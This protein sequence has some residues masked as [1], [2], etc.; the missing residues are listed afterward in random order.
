M[1]NI[2][3]KKVLTNV[4]SFLLGKYSCEEINIILNELKQMIDFEESDY[5]DITTLGLSYED[6]QLLLSKINEKGVNRKSNGIYY[7]ANDVVKFIYANAIKSLYGIIKPTNLHVL[8]L[9]GVPYNSFCFHKKVFDPTCGVGE[10][11]IVALSIK[12]DLLDLHKIKVSSADIL[13]IVGTIYG[14]DINNESVLITKI[15]LFLYVLNR[16]GTSKIVGLS[17]QL[18]NN[19]YSFDFINMPNDFT[20]QYEIIIG[21]PPYVE[22]AKCD[23]EPIKKYGNVYA[24]VLE[25]AMSRLRNDGVMGF[26]IPLSYVSTPRMKAIRNVLFEELSQQ[27]ILSYCD[28]PDCLFPGVH[29][30]LCIVIGKK[31]NSHAHQIYT[32]NYRFWYKEEREKLFESSST[33]LNERY[34][35]EFIPKLGN[36]IE[37]AIYDKVLQYPNKL[38]DEL[39]EGDEHIFINMRASFWIKAFTNPHA[40]NEYKEFK[41]RGSKMRDLIFCILNS[42]L[43]WWFWI[44]TSDCWHITNKELK[45]FSLPKNLI[46]NAMLDEC[47]SLARLLER[48]LELTKKYVGTKQTEYEYKHRE[49]L[50]EIHNID[51]YINNM[52]GLT[53]E[54]SLYIKNFAAIYRIS[55]GVQ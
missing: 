44:C 26:V 16:Y 19:F 40:S 3:I 1:D 46:N 27:Y 7:T 21:N 29:Q 50:D 6:I 53:E 39:Q 25:N 37:L 52:Y 28:R 5:C 36:I 12:L 43:F 38:I 20:E 41:C 11:L 49:C 13:K 47:V 32:G 35:D 22:D 54:E 31:Q 30:K 23:T 8:D 9:N 42:S 34:T 51:D 48:K 33:V 17:H 15:R 10:F 55:G 45:I 18:N 24:N 14:N 4:Y 2:L